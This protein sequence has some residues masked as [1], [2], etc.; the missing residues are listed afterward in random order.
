[1]FLVKS[2]N[3]NGFAKGGLPE[4]SNLPTLMICNLKLVQVIDLKFGQQETPSQFN[5]W[6]KFNISLDI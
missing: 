5:G 3:V 2:L 1:M 6:E 4:R